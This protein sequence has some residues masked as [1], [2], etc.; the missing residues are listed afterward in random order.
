MFMIPTYSS[1]LGD[2]LGKSFLRGFYNAEDEYMRELERQRKLEETIQL[3]QKLAELEDRKRQGLL[4]Q[5]LGGYI[6]Q[7]LPQE[8]EFSL[9][10]PLS[11]TEQL[12]N[13]FNY[14]YQK[15]LLSGLLDEYPEMR[16]NIIASVYG[17]NLPSPRYFSDRSGIYRVFG[18]DV[19][20]IASFPEPPPK[21]EKKQFVI[22]TIGNYLLSIDP[23][24][25]KP[26]YVQEFKSVRQKGD[27]KIIQTK[28]YTDGTYWYFDEVYTAPDGREIRR[29]KH[30]TA[31]PNQ[32]SQSQKDDRLK[33]IRAVIK[34]IQ[35]RYNIA[36]DP[37]ASTKEALD[38]VNMIAKVNPRDAERLKRA[39][40]ALWRLTEGKIKDLIPQPTFKKK[41]Q[42][43]PFLQ[44]NQKYN[45]LGE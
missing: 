36:P 11:Q 3:Q 25:G 42:T 2:L 28:P 16:N 37:F 33:Y 26:V 15:G 8:T 22:K 5:L 44:F 4:R 6:A 39:Y 20:Q 24:T 45:L 13:K 38:A 17:I 23:E 31:P 9:L 10:K 7:Y 19:K 40:E 27:V 32:R 41:V 12:A 34:G 35:R 29:I 43:D 30:R 21:P 1:M 18:D 14:S